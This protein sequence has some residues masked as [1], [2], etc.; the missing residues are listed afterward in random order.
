MKT[1]ILLALC[2]GIIVIMLISWP[3]MVG[4][5]IDYPAMLMVDGILYV[6]TLT[7]I[8]DIQEEDILGYTKLHT[9]KE[10]RRNGQANFTRGT[11]YAATQNGLAVKRGEEWILFKA[12][13]EGA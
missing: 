2:A 4:A 11:A 3:T 10:P 8:S 7:P 13:G 9:N 5:K 12:Y 6:D 1:K